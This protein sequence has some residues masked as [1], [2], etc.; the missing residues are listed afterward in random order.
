MN[1]WAETTTK[2]VLKGQPLLHEEATTVTQAKTRWP[3]GHFCWQ[4]RTQ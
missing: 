1:G 3:W 2:A 4:P